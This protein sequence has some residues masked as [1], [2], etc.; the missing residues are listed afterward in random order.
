MNVNPEKSSQSSLELWG[1]AECTVNRV[2]DQYFEQLARTGHSPRLSDFDRFAELGVTRLRHAVLWENVAPVEIGDAH[3][4]WPDS[5][6]ERIR[7]LQIRPI[8]GLLHHG[9]GPKSTSLLDP[10]FAE[11]LAR[12]A[13]TVARRYPWV[14][15]YT[16]VNEPL[17]TARFSALYGHWYPHKK[18]EYSFAKALLNQ[19][20]GVVLSMRAI[21][22]VNSSARLVQT[23]DLAKIFSTP[24]LAYQAEFENERRWCSYDLLCGQLH[25]NHRMWGHFLWAGIDE[26]E[27]MWFIENPCPPDVIGIN[28]YLSGNRFLD[29]NLER[30]PVEC[31][32]GN[33][34]DRYADVLAARVLESG[35]INV[36]ELL[37]AAWKRYGSPVAITECHNGC[38][39]EEQMRWLREVWDGA[40]RAKTGGADVLAVTAW[41]LLGA[42]DWN[43]LVT[44]KNDHYEPGLYDI[45]SSRPR[46]TV[47]VEMVRDLAAGREYDHPVLDAPGWW[48]SSRRFIYGFSLDR[49]GNEQMPIQERVKAGRPILI[50]GANGMLARGF[51]RICDARGI[52]YRALT[53]RACDITN[54]QSL[55]RALFKFHPWAVV[56]LA[57]YSRVDDA[58]L[59]PRQCYRA[60]TDGA[61]LLA[62]ECSQRGIQFLTASSDLVFDGSKDGAYVESD[63]PVPMNHYGCS[64]ALA[65]QAVLHSFPSALI[66]RTGPVFSPWDQ[67]NFLAK[68]LHALRNEHP[69]RAPE[70][71]MVSPTYL[72]DLVHAA[73]DLIID[74]ESGIWHLANIGATSPADLARQAARLANVSE[75]TLH[76]CNI[77]EMHLGAERPA[78][79]VLTSERAV[80]LPTLRDAVARFVRDYEEPTVPLETT[81]ASSLAA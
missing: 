17:T 19:C 15:E 50:T 49:S 72:P 8:V 3:W 54:A 47:L 27:L 26:R 55:H 25:R 63:R 81:F 32:G 4:Q 28:H 20:R 80:L 1:G 14:E 40:E 67:N 62:R 36:D 16:P 69:F 75:H 34:R 59:N 41:S 60:N 46:P 22:N 76:G 29:E 73:L 44:Q 64:K 11:K 21:R 53:R 68:A 6:L 52:P 5:S 37:M 39:R 18:D 10:L 58:E 79:S 13:E 7:E 71:V 57:G 35:A 31:H 65:E 9:S 77:S 43:Q 45:R 33:G 48:Q 38:T 66:I 24:K 42:Y 78:H 70:D 61:L 30:Y 2:G 51:A 23:E 74:N 56:N 12:Y